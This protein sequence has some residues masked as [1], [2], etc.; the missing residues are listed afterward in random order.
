[1]RFD[2]PTVVEG[3]DGGGGDEPLAVRAQ[4]AEQAGGARP[5]E[6]SPA[7]AWRINL[8]QRDPRSI[9][10]VGPRA[11]ASLVLGDG[12][13]AVGAVEPVQH[14]GPA[15]TGQLLAHVNMLGQREG[16][17]HPLV[18]L[19]HHEAAVADGPVGKVHCDELLGGP[20]KSYPR[21]A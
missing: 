20:L 19:M 8:D 15:T 16:L 17:A 12:G 2:H 5:H 14:D 1:M 11:G 6:V 4:A 3:E 10:V 9:R 13:W 21:A 18:R 7:P